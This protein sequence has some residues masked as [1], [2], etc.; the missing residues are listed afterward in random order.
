MSADFSVAFRRSDGTEVVAF[1]GSRIEWDALAGVAIPG[2]GTITA[3]DRGEQRA[4]AAVIF[5]DR[6]DRLRAVTAELRAGLDGLSK[7]TGAPPMVRTGFDGDG[8]FLFVD[9][10]YF[11]SAV[12]IGVIRILS[13][14]HDLSTYAE[15][16][17]EY[18]RGLDA[19]RKWIGS[20]WPW[21]SPAP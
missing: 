12:A 17:E 7:D 14:R 16:W 8:G 3:F 19:W 1:D 21:W 10:D 18:K 20:N 2:T 6:N 15:A 13:E 4:P 9:G 11:A 5:V